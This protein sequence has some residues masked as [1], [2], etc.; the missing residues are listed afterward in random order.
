VYH[1]SYTGY[2]ILQKNTLSTVPITLSYFHD[3]TKGC[4]LMA[5]DFDWF[6]F[7]NS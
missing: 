2:P 4:R 6:K 7:T 3:F 1:F 5:L